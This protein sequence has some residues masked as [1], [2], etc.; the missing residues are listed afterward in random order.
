M[1]KKK[2]PQFERTDKA[3]MYAMI[4]LLSDHSFESI[5]IQDILDETPVSKGTFYAHYADKY[6]V[7]ERMLEEYQRIELNMRSEMKSKSRHEQLLVAQKTSYR[8]TAL[9]HALL[10]IHTD[11]VD[12]EKSIK[13][14][15]QKE[16]MEK[17][18]KTDHKELK[19]LVYA[20]AITAYQIYFIHQSKDLDNAI[21]L[22]DDV[23]E[24]VYRYFKKS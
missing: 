18:K 17:A 21:N 6:E 10:K 15:Y 20:S 1:E 19:A 22:L 4:R 23:M 16:Y 9:I 13:G 2:S 3:I 11:K 7:A 5:T 24:D 12:L 8:D 14:N